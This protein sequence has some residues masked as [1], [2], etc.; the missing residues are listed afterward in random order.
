MVSRCCIV[1]SPPHRS[2][3]SAG[4]RRCTRPG[5]L[6]EAGSS[7]A[8][9]RAASL[10]Q[11]TDSND[12]VGTLEN[13]DQLVENTFSALRPRL[14]VLFEDR[15]RFADCVQCQLLIG[16]CYL[17]IHK[18]AQVSGEKDQVTFGE[19]SRFP[20]AIDQI[21][22][23]YGTVAAKC[24]RAKIGLASIGACIVG[25]HRATTGRPTMQSQ[26]NPGSLTRSDNADGPRERSPHDR[27]PHGG[28]QRNRAPAQPVQ[29]LALRVA[30][31]VLQRLHHG[32]STTDEGR[33]Q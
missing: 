5:R 28:R 3:R 12:Q 25:A 30:C 16:H 23:R 29:P 26:R 2:S 24:Y 15:L 17:P 8:R 10:L 6:I 1:V 31:G 18:L 9:S 14:K 27:R 33:A 21:L 32:G 22:F 11:S 7:L 13:F 4:A 19:Y 20:H